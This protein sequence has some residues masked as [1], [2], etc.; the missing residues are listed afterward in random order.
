MEFGYLDDIKYNEMYEAEDK[1]E[2]G[3]FKIS[4]KKF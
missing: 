4:P 2:Y 3:G 1:L